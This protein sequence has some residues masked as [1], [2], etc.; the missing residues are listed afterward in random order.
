MKYNKSRIL[1][2]WE[3]TSL[4]VDGTIN[5]HKVSKDSNGN[6]NV[7][8][9]GQGFTQHEKYDISCE[10]DYTACAPL[11]LSWTCDNEEFSPSPKKNYSNPIRITFP[12]LQ[13][14]PFFNNGNS[15]TARY[16]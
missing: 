5:G 7:H 4:T 12:G 6:V 1:G 14:Q 10:R 2:Y 11:A 8:P 13:L 15:T 9:K 16:I 3:W